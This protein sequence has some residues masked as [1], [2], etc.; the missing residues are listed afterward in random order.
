[1]WSEQN[2]KLVCEFFGHSGFFL[3]GKYFLTMCPSFSLDGRVEI[4]TNTSCRHIRAWKD[5]L[6]LSK[7]VGGG[8][9]DYDLGLGYVMVGNL[10]R[11]SV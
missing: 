11:K 5:Y 4:L 1:M 10:K 3:C 2:P 9:M 6:S 8:L 7:C